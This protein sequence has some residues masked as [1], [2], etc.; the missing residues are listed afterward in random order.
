MSE[1]TVALRASYFFLSYAHSPPLAGTPQVTHDHWVRTFFGDLSDAVRRLG[2][3]RL[4]I[5]SGFFDQEIPIGSDWRA[6]LGQAL[7]LAEVF[8][9]L[10]SPGYFARSWPGREWACF[11]RRL[12]AAGI[13]NPVDRFTPV[14][15][16]PLKPG[17]NPEGLDKALAIGAADPAYVENGLRAMLRLSP[18]HDAYHKIVRQLA[19]EIVDLAERQT[20]PPSAV[21]DIDDVQSPFSPASAAAF[22]VAVA[23]PPGSGL[24]PFPGA[25]ELPVADYAA[26]V[27]EQLDFVV[28]ATDLDHASGRLATTPGVIL[29]D[30]RYAAEESALVLLAQAVSGRP[31]VLPVLVLSRGSRDDEGELAQR[32]RATLDKAQSARS[33]AARQAVTGVESLEQ[34][35]ALMPFLI[36]EAVRQFLRHGPIERSAAQPGSRPRLR[37]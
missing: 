34:F 31:W 25:Q 37:D 3:P 14:L 32:V 27:A 16:I 9:P 1:T 5:A 28:L 30:P 24:R 17:E 36:A 15:W 21:P 13:R 11:K 22:A 35:V 4:G 7:S 2:S 6:S 12:T 20:I 8:V 26:T 33:D 29:I 23:S 18:Y 10:Y 19:M